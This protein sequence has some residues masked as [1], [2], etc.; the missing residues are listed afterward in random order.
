LCGLLTTLLLVSTVLKAYDETARWIAPRL[1][2]LTFTAEGVVTRVLQPYEVSKGKQVFLRVDTT[3]DTQAP[4]KASRGDGRSA[5]VNITRRT[6]TLTPIAPFSPMIVRLTAETPEEVRA[7]NTY[8]LDCCQF[9]KSYRWYRSLA[10]LAAFLIPTLLAFTATLALTV[11]LSAIAWPLCRIARSRR[12]YSALWNMA[13]R[14]ST[15]ALVLLALAVW[16]VL[17]LASLTGLSL[18]LIPASYLALAVR[19]SR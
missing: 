15:A 10:L 13:A 11:V 5:I 18:F 12:S 9:V 16:G 6:L 7:W 4:P 19:F 1:P 3:Q 17:P 14:A 8:H 2:E